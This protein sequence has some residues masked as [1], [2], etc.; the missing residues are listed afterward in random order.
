MPLTA[1]SFQHDS[2]VAESSFSVSY[3][4]KHPVIIACYLTSAFPI[5]TG[6]VP[7]HLLARILYE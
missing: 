7:G 5:A 4:P 1:P 6:V 3:I 2:E